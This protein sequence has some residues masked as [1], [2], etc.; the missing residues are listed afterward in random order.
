MNKDGSQGLGRCLALS[1]KCHNELAGSIGESEIFP[2]ILVPGTDWGGDQRRHLGLEKYGLRCS[3]LS[4][5]TGV[6][7]HLLCISDV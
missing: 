3:P 5:K 7:T 2:S 6:K 1:Q 4:R